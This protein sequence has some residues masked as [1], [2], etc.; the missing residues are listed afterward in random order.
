M[1]DSR[2]GVDITRGVY[3][4]K[5]VNTKRSQ[6]SF[7]NTEAQSVHSALQNTQIRHKKQK[8]PTVTFL[9]FWEEIDTG[10]RRSQGVYQ[11]C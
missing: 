5:K 6:R 4:N 9:T 7:K 8:H 11:E 2:T 3:S 10:G 1:H